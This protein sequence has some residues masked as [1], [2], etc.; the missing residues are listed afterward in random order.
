M[1]KCDFCLIEE[2]FTEEVVGFILFFNLSIVA[3]QY[4]VRFRGTM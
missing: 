3:V 4:Y 2:G 1:G